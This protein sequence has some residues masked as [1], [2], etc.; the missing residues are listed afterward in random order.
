VT[1]QGWAPDR[2][3]IFTTGFGRRLFEGGD[4]RTNLAP[5]LGAEEKLA[6]CMRGLNLDPSTITV[7]VVVPKLADGAEVEDIRSQAEAAAFGDELLQRLRAFTSE[8]DSAVHLSLAGG[9]KTMSYIAGLCLSLVARPQDVLSHV[10]ISPAALESQPHFWW[11]S[12]T[13]PAEGVDRS[14]A[15][16]RAADAMVELHEAPLVRLRAFE[17]PGQDVDLST[18]VAR[19]SA[20]LDPN[21]ELVFDIKAQT[22]SVGPMA[23]R[24]SSSHHAALY[25][26]ILLAH[27][28][29][30]AVLEPDG[31]GLDA[32]CGGV[33][34]RGDSIFE[35]RFRDCY[36]A[37]MQFMD[38]RSPT[39]A[40]A[41]AQEKID[42]RTFRNSAERSRTERKVWF[43]SPVISR[44]RAT[45]SGAFPLRLHP[46]LIPE[47]GSLSIQWDPRRIRIIEP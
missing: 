24:F 31:F 10:L 46:F 5:L 41:T 47:K 1:H 3:V 9:R 22:I 40:L 33:D 37:S 21:A 45:L 29:G 4:A 14:G 42:E 44:L 15:R 13:D 16:W 26:L 12:Q 8:P 6:A 32:L 43:G 36:A 18:T 34:D 25:H 2:I 11:P 17:M 35:Q 7:E 27:A 28:E 19:A 39:D 30:W 20:A 38:G 23:C